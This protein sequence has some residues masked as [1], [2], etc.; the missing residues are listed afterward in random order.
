[1]TEIMPPSAR[2]VEAVSKMFWRRV[3]VNR[4]LTAEQVIDDTGRVRGYVDEKVLATMPGVGNGPEEVKV[5]FFDL[6]YDPT[7]KELESEYQLRRLKPDAVALA[8]ANKDDPAL[9]DERPNAC[10]WGLGEDGKASCAVFLRLCDWRSVH[11]HRRDDRWIRRYRFA[12]V[13]K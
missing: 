4:A 11:V 2:H 12:G 5:W 9:A 10:Q 13:R 6:D 3:R 1:M 7:P 8:K